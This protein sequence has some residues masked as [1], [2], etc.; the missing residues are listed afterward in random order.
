MPYVSNTIHFD[1]WS[2]LRRKMKPWLV[3][4]T[5]PLHQTR[6]LEYLRS[7]HFLTGAHSDI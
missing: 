7:S 4:R 3:A 2:M 5:P 6:S 1:I